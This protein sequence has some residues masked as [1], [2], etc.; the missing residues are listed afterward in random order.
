MAAMVFDVAVAVGV[1]VVVLD[2][3]RSSIFHVAGLLTTRLRF[4]VAVIWRENSAGRSCLTTRLD[5]NPSIATTCHHQLQLIQYQSKASDILHPYYRETMFPSSAARTAASRLATRVLV[6][7]SSRA[8]SVA[9]AS[10]AQQPSLM[11]VRFFASVSA[12]NYVM[13]RS[14]RGV[15]ALI[16]V[17]ISRYRLDE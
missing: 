4:H 5:S 11:A 1:G 14:C 6:S 3:A 9:A 12:N 17:Y 15:D 2:Q 16:D 13:C 8:P 10:V 7:S